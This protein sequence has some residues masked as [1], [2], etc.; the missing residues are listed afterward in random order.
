[1]SFLS[2]LFGKS[3]P[4]SAAPAAGTPAAAAEP[5]AAPDTAARAREEETLV[6]QAI[7]AGDMASVGR[8]VLEG[9]SSGVRQRAANAVSD[10]DQLHELIR[11]TRH[12]KDKKVYRILTGKRDELLAAMRSAEKLQADVDAAAAALVEHCGRAQDAAFAGRL[13]RLEAGWSALAAHAT[14]DLQREVARYLESAHAAIE[15]HRQ[16]LEAEAER[17]R[18]AARAAEEARRQQLLEEQAALESA[19]AEA[20][21]VEAERVAEREAERL[22]RAEE[23]AQARKLAGLLRQAQAALDDGATARADRLREAIAGQLPQAPI[24][25]PWFPRQL[26]QLD[27]RLAEL[28]DW[29]TFRATPRRAELL[30][31]MQ[32]LVG[33]D[34]SPEELARQVRR[35]R[36]EWRTLSR[37]AGEEVTPEWQQFEEAAERAYE[38]CR[39]HFARQAE[40]RRENQAKREELLERLAAFAAEQAGEEPDWRAIGQVLF[41]ARDEWRRY[42]PVDTAVVK[43]LQARFHALLGELQSRLEAEY[44][45]NVEA[46]RA[47]IA[48]AAELVSLEDTRRA[49]EELKQ[50][51]RSWKTVG[52]VPHRQDNA[53]WDEFRRHCDAVFQRSSQESAAQASALEASQAEAVALCDELERIAG[54]DGEELRAGL[55]QVKDLRTRFESLE[56]PRSS[57]RELRQRFSRA[58]DRCNEAQ[59]RQRA[60]AARQGWADL[61]A[62]AAEVRAYALAAVEGRAAGEVEALREAAESAVAGLADAPRGTRAILEQQLAAIASGAVN[63][64]LAANAAALRLLCVRAELIAGLATPPE[65]LEL[66]RE[67]QM[68]R[69]VQSLAHGERDTPAGLDELAQEWIAV[70]PVEPAEYGQLFARFERCRHTL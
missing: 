25:P 24:L 47:L 50:L 64:D 39:E 32:S 61:F 13:E 59:H 44:A 5:K 20:R 70:G 37:G 49:I 6:E 29:K 66:R 18:S 12:G 53:L 19:A 10:L 21:R 40:L 46:K 2:R 52:I 23:E 68:Q 60:A 33:A 31:Q 62:A 4:A 36:D 57:A 15:A 67:L 3:P 30:E 28:K 35:L 58:A 16:A 9:H 65:D 22:K 45:R 42:A 17:Q 48:R 56:L 51:Q 26:Q 41:E 63:A 38:P 27:A 55:E 11:A 34:M 69:L 54:L 7:A 43:S 1:M 14:P 8:W